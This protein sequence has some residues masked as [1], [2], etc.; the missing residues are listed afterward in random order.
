MREGDGSNEEVAD[1]YLFVRGDN[2]GRQVEGFGGIGGCEDGDIMM[3]E[4]Q[5]GG[6]TMVA[7]GV[8]D[9]AAPDRRKGYMVGDEG[10]GEFFV[11]EACVDED[12]IVGGTEE[13]GV[14]LGGAAEGEEADV[15]G[16]LIVSGR[17]EDLR[18]TEML[19]AGVSGAEAS[20]REAS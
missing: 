4:E 7:V 6:L 16:Y 3:G 10:G 19:R 13:V 20:R 8:S 12:A 2:A 17:L 9:E 15:H 11:G 5:V 1:R 14:A 18:R